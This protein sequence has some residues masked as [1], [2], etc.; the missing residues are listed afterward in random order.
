M[1]NKLKNGIWPNIAPLGYLNDRK[2][3]TIVIDPKKAPLVKKMFEV[4]ASGDY[5]LA[6]LQETINAMGLTG[7]RGAKISKSSYQR[8]LQNPVYYGII[9]FNGQ[10]YEGIHEPLITK[11]LFGQVQEV[12]S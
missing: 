11:K 4:Y 6:Q 5:T 12:M 9:R 7:V 3:K 8:M 10:F 1:R 2:A